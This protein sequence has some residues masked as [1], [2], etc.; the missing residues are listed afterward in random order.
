[1]EC[2][3]RVLLTLLKCLLLP[4]LKPFKTAPLFL[5][6]LSAAEPQLRGGLSGKG[7]LRYGSFFMMKEAVTE[8]PQG[9][10]S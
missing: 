10:G 9:P 1:M 2:Q 3:S 8:N 5:R 4:P 6:C 7:G